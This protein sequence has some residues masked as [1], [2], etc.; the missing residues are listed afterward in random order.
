MSGDRSGFEVGWRVFKY[1]VYFLGA[2]LVLLIVI[3]SLTRKEGPPKPPQVAEAPVK[4]QAPA[5]ATKPPAPPVPVTTPAPSATARVPESG[6]SLVAR[7]DRAERENGKVLDILMSGMKTTTRPDEAKQ[8]A[9]WIRP[10]RFRG[11]LPY[12]YFLG[13]YLAMQRDDDRRAE[14]LEALG[15]AALIYRVDAGKCNDPTANQAVPIVENQL[16]IPSVR[17]MLS[18]RRAT[19]LLVVMRAMEAERSTAGKR[20]TPRWICAHGL[21]GGNAPSAEAFEAHRQA[22]LD[23]FVKEF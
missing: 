9:E 5:P 20:E 13:I 6:E 22:V 17:K 3:G 4:P 11:E 7:L 10:R 12:L 1:V 23:R 18:E 14:G 8:V 21:R 19:H 2:A 16:G 15:A